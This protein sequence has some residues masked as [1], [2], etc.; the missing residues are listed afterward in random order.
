[1][2]TAIHFF[3]MAFSKPIFYLLLLLMARG[4]TK[5]GLC[6]AGDSPHPSFPSPAYEA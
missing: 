2:E 1:M 5:D 4:W 6:F 3:A